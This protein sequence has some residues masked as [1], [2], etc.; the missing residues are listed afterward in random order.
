MRTSWQVDL[1]L[2]P[3]KSEL[4]FPI[5]SKNELHFARVPDEEMTLLR[6][7]DDAR[8]R[9]LLPV[10]LLDAVAAAMD[11]PYSSP[12]MVLKADSQRII[13]NL[14]EVIQRGLQDC[15]ISLVPHF[16]LLQKQFYDDRMRP[17]L[18]R[19][20]IRFIRDGEGANCVR[21]DLPKLLDNGKDSCS[22]WEVAAYE[23]LL[24]K[25]TKDTAL[26]TAVGDA[27]L[28]AHKAG[29]NHDPAEDSLGGGIDRASPFV[30]VWLALQGTQTLA[31]LNLCRTYVNSLMPHVLSKRVRIDFG[32]L[33]DEDATRLKLT[34]WE[35]TTA[36][37]GGT[38]RELTT[39]ELLVINRTSRELLAVPFTGKDAPSKA[40]EFAIPEVII[41]LTVVAY[42][43][44]GLRDRDVV[45]LLTRLLLDSSKDFGTEPDKREESQMLERWKQSAQQNWDKLHGDDSDP[46]DCP[47]LEMLQPSDKRHILMLRTLLG[48]E[49]LAIAYYLDTIVFEQTQRDVVRGGGYA[50]EKLSASGMDL[51]SDT[52]FK[53]SVGFSGTPSDLLPHAM[54]PC[55]GT[56][57]DDAKTIN[58]LT[59]PDIVSIHFVEPPWSSTELLRM[60]ARSSFQVLID[61]G[62]LVSAARFELHCNLALNPAL[63]RCTPALSLALKP[64]I[65]SCA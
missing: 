6:K 18:A 12:E 63:N 60:I 26:I 2:H 61:A 25:T 51:G 29:R 62:A 43:R 57:G 31:L 28:A 52:L 55:K 27:A 8:Y 21:E 14:R 53:C 19:W 38:E 1:V 4:N 40:A 20:A 23:Y 33:S 65:R 46:P 5:G 11:E 17:E 10:H 54:K 35:E 36:R 7:D 30:A 13:S 58:V 44:E 42:R 64:C 56:K 22:F 49:P 59:D 50:G 16:V 32:L 45:R 34:E 9:W 39:E 3:L 47:K 48:R 15:H 41:G 24:D 37:V